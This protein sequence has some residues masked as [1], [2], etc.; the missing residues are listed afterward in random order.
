[1][2]SG[3]VHYGLGEMSHTAGSGRNVDTQ[4]QVVLNQLKSGKTYH[5]KVVSRDLFGREQ[6]S[7]P[8]T[9]STAKAQPRSKSA[10]VSL[11]RDGPE[12]EDSNFQRVGSDYLFRLQ[13][14]APS[15]VFVGRKGAVRKQVAD[16]ATAPTERQDISS[17]EGLS[18]GRGL[19][20]NACQNCHHR[21][22]AATHPVGVLP[23][24]GMVIPP[25]YPTLPDGRISCVSC[26][27]VHSSNNEYLARK[28][29][30][31]DLCVGCHQDM[32]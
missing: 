12:I 19:T 21:Q 27:T 3:Q 2:T 17:H 18:S 9:F 32:L 15:T 20:I 6:E 10:A 11:D 30:R 29:G 5:F 25:E 26:H 7:Q 8:L 24:P 16:V 28:P 22:I 4:H 23:K 13:L 14:A 31:R 1:V